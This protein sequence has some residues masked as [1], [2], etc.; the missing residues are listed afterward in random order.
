MSS[1]T[2]ALSTEGVPEQSRLHR[3]TVLKNKENKLLRIL[4]LKKINY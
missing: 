3:E 1:R 2:A 4:K